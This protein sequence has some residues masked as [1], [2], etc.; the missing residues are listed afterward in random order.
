M[1]QQDFGK[2]S[3]E[4]YKPYTSGHVLDVTA[5]LLRLA[6]SQVLGDSVAKNNKGRETSGLP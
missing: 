5:L 6:L 3:V 4:G 2:A 1:T